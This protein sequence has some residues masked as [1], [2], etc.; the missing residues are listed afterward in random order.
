MIRQ[1]VAEFRDKGR[2]VLLVSHQLTEVE[3][4][5][6]R[7][8]VLVNGKIVRIDTVTQLTRDPATGKPQALEKGVHKLYANNLQ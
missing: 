2:T 7:V 8:A 4:L 3:Q 6:D 5:C 1:L